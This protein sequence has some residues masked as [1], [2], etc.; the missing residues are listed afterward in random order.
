MPTTVQICEESRFKTR[1]QEAFA[2]TPIRAGLQGCDDWNCV[3]WIEKAL[4][5]VADDG[6]ALGSCHTDWTYVKDTAM[7]YVAKK[8]ADHR[9]DGEGSLIKV[10]YQHGMH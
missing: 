1:L 5:W 8:A 9:F 6:K 2:K 10:K 3:F 7:W 4:R